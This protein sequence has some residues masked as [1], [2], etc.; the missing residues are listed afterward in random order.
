MCKKTNSFFLL[1]IKRSTVF[2]NH[3]TFAKIFKYLHIYRSMYIKLVKAKPSLFGGKTKFCEPKLCFGTLRI[4]HF[5]EI[6]VY[7][8]TNLRRVST[9]VPHYVGYLPSPPY[10]FF[11]Q[12][13]FCMHHWF[14]WLCLQNFVLHAAM[15]RITTCKSEAFATQCR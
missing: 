5:I 14:G 2:L 13:L 9:L 8:V 7:P 15:I 11:C 1:F 4:V 10:T 6:N 12:T 3:G